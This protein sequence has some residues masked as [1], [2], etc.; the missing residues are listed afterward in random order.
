MIPSLGLRTPLRL[1]AAVATALLACTLPGAVSGQQRGGTVVVA[2][3]ANPPTL[4]GMATAAEA[5]RNITM[6]IYETL[7]AYSET[8]APIPQ[9][10]EGVA[11]SDDGLSY[12]FTLRQG[13]RFHNGKEM[14][15]RDVRASIERYRRVGA[16]KSLLAPVE[17]VEVTGDHEVTLRLSARTPMFLEAF[18]SPRAP[19]VIIPEE[20]AAAE[21]GRISMVG[22]GPYRL[23]EYVPDSHVRLA[24]FEDYAEDT[25]YAGSDGFGGRKAPHFDEVVFR[26]MP[27]PGAQVAALEA[28]EVHVLERIGVPSGRRLAGSDAIVVHENMPW[29]FTVLI[30]NTAAGP[31]ANRDFREAVQA[32][33]NMEEIMAIVG[34]GLFDLNHRWQYRGSTYDPG[35]VGRDR[36]NRSDLARTAELLARAGY[37]GEEVIL[38]TDTASQQNIRTAVVAEQQLRAAGINVVIRQFDQP[39]VLEL[40]RR[41]EGWHLTTGQ[42]GAAPYFGPVDTLA[43]MTGAQPLFLAP[44]PQI[45]A[46]FRELANGPTVEARQET[47]RRAQAYLYESFPIIKIGDWGKMEATRSNV[48]GYVPFRIPRMY[49]VWFEQ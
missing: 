5:A 4:D 16:T 22:T 13:V 37:A 9:L 34:E 12:V 29:A 10:A 26:I 43:T 30:F 18:A 23:V 17:S 33:L 38:V 25:R 36:Y 19:V 46:L 15:A 35:E 7:Y 2:Q 21:V 1:A 24:R 39:T 6:H 42:M 40:R 47:F 32:A 28:G 31:G 41:P 11:I 8:I 27:D 3:A 48:R 49:N 14:T 45:D 20:D 44:D